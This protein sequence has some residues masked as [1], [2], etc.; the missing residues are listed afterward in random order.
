MFDHIHISSTFI[1]CFNPSFSSSK[2]T[3]NQD[4]NVLFSLPNFTGKELDEET[5]Y[6]YFGARYMDYELMTGWLSVD[7]MSDKYPSLSPYNYCAW[8]SMRLV[9]PDGEETIECDD[10]WKTSIDKNTGQK[11]LVK[12]NTDGGD[13]YQSFVDQLG[14]L[15]STRDFVEQYS[16]M[17]YSVSDGTEN[18]STSEENGTKI[19]NI[20][21]DIGTI[22]G[23]LASLTFSKSRGKWLG[24]NGKFYPMNFNGNGTTGGKLKFA[25]TTSGYLK[26][27]GASFSLLSAA[28]TYMDYR[29]GDIS[30]GGFASDMVGTGLGFVPEIGWAL[31]LDWNIFSNLE[32]KYGLLQ[33][34]QKK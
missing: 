27:A 1:C 19:S 31:C 25:K 29:Q 13:T 16:N 30:V 18:I 34:I 20:L 3:L 21:S 17:G 22:N 8:N 28:S 9:D 26:G 33:K 24:K 2:T 12:V 14:P 15:C 10:G 32:A 5:G 4:E 11:T 23:T 7:P 6:G